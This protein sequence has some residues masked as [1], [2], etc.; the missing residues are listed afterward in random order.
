MQIQDIQLEQ[1]L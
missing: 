1:C